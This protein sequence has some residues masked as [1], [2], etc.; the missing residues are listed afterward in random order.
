MLCVR[1]TK[2]DRAVVVDMFV[3]AK[4][5]SDRT[6]ARTHFISL[7]KRNLLIY[8]CPACARAVLLAILSRD[9]YACAPIASRCGA[10]KNTEK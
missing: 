4:R 9:A 7:P 8:E 2:C 1:A 6:D 3:F 10:T 5:I